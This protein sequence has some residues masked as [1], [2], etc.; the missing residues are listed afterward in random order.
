M[1][2]QPRSGGHLAKGIAVALVVALGGL[3]VAQRHTPA[4]QAAPASQATSPAP[5]PVVE[6]PPP[7]T[8]N[9]PNF[10]RF[11]VPTEKVKIRVVGEGFEVINTD[12]ALTG[13]ELAFSGVTDRGE[14]IPFSLKLPP[15][16]PAATADA[17]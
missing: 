17:N 12:Q 1:N 7:A 15:P 10:V 8:S 4:E 13:T 9:G 2:A 14:T 3:I 16:V 11:D 5:A 6:A